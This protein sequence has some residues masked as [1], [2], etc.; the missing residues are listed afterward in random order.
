MHGVVRRIT[1][2][3]HNLEVSGGA[4][5]DVGEVGR[6]VPEQAVLGEA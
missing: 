5:L 1:D 3:T 4:F 2:Q 6:W